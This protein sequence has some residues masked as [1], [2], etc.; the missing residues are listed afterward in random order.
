[1]NKIFSFLS[2][3]QDL[4]RSVAGALCDG[5]GSPPTRR[6][7]SPRSPGRWCIRPTTTISTSLLPIRDIWRLSA[8]RRRLNEEEEEERLEV[9]LQLFARSAR[10]CRIVLTSL[11]YPTIPTMPS[12]RKV[13]PTRISS[14][15]I[16]EPGSI[17]FTIGKDK[18]MLYENQQKI[19]ADFYKS[20]P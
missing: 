11:R 4:A 13:K 17:R 2:F 3:G 8:G 16:T 10:G 14:G 19:F 9:P 12:S 20:V 6:W 15:S 1:M 7:P 5:P 18:S